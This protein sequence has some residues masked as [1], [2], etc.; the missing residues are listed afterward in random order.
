MPS[1]LQEMEQRIAVMVEKSLREQ[2]DKFNRLRS[3]CRQGFAS[4]HDSITNSKSVLEGK[5]TLSEEQLRKEIGHVK[6]MVVLV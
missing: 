6:N 3:E 4:V 5:L 1:R 2:A